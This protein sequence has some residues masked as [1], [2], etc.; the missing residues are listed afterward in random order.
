MLGAFW[1]G[2]ASSSEK[3]NEAAREY[4]PYALAMIAVISAELALISAFLLASGSWWMW[5]GAAAT[6]LA[7]WSLRW[8]RTCLRRARSL[9]ARL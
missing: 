6:V 3:V 5:L 8:T 9:A 2:R 4:G 7:L 1:T